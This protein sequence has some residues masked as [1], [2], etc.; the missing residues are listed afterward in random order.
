MHVSILLTS[1]I[2]FSFVNA[3]GQGTVL[4]ANGVV[5]VDQNSPNDGSLS[6]PNIYNEVVAVLQFSDHIAAL[7]FG[8]VTANS[9]TDILFGLIKQACNQT[10]YPASANTPAQIGLYHPLNSE[11]LD[12]LVI[13]D[14]LTIEGSVDDTDTSEGSNSTSIQDLVNQDLVGTWQFSIGSML[15]ATLQQKSV[16]Y[17]KPLNFTPTDESV[18]ANKV[19]KYNVDIGYIGQLDIRHPLLSAV[20]VA[21]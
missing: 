21:P 16:L 20:Q 5:N 8:P 9:T 13:G 10:A 17:I 11:P 6:I 12:Q 3:Q 7:R 18:V 1:L 19:M 2:G 4:G 15:Q 14:T